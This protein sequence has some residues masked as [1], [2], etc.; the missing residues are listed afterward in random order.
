MA[1]LVETEAYPAEGVGLPDGS[2][3]MPLGQIP[4]PTTFSLTDVGESAARL[5]SIVTFDRRG[6]V[7]WLDDFE[8]NLN[9]WSLAGVGVGGGVALSILAARSGASSCALTTGDVINDWRRITRETPYPVL[10]RLG[11]E[12]SFVY[13]DDISEYLWQMEVYTG[14]AGT[15]TRPQVR[16]VPGAPPTLAIVESDGVTWTPLS[17]TVSL[18]EGLQLFNTLKLVG[19]FLTNTY[20]RVILNNVEYDASAHA[21]QSVPSVAPAHLAIHFHVATRVNSNQVVYADDAIITQNE[22]ENITI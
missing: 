14:P 2:A 15:W 11:F 18:A 8:N 4:K 22:P 10:G 7:I 6:D 16:F 17:I 12:I 19:N 20:E 3:P 5:G 1:I 9:K 21:M 13:N